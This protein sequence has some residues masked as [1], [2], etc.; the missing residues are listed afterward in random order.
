MQDRSVIAS[1][2]S[3]RAHPSHSS[4]P[5][6]SA[7]SRSAASVLAERESL[8]EWT[9]LEPATLGVTG[10]YSNQLNYHSSHSLRFVENVFRGRKDVKF[11]CASRPCQELF[12]RLP[13]RITD[14]RRRRGHPKPNRTSWTCRPARSREPGR[15]GA[16]DDESQCPRGSAPSEQEAPAEKGP[17]QPTRA[18]GAGARAADGEQEKLQGKLERHA[19]VSQ[20]GKL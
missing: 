19:P 13:S 11:I 12:F 8:A 7:S 3:A 9:G 14:S 15:P 6:A 17:R 1:E 5:S 20:L 4:P 16:R 2:R 10:R 18:C